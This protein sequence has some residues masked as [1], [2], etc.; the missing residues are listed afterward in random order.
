MWGV[1]ITANVGKLKSLKMS[2]LFKHKKPQFFNTKSA[3]TAALF[4]I[5]QPPLT[6]L[7]GQ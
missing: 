7:S 5:G 1:M 4:Y 2:L 3:L 6:N